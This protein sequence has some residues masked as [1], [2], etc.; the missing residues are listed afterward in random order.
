MSRLVIAGLALVIA[1]TAC[2]PPRKAAVF[3]RATLSQAQESEKLGGRHIRIVQP[4]DTLFG[5]AFAN[6]L[7]AVKLAAWNGVSSSAKLQI[8]QRLRLTQP[9]G[10][11]SE[12][13][14]QSEAVRLDRSAR[15]KT[16]KPSRTEPI[17]SG[18][19]TVNTNETNWR[20]PVGGA[21]LSRFNL[22]RGQQGV[23][24]GAPLGEPV[25]AAKSGEVVYVG[26]GLKGYGNL[27]IVKHHADFI[28]AYAHNLETFVREGQSVV[29]GQRLATVGQYK[30]RSALHFQIRQFGEPIDPLIHLP[31]IN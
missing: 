20:W 10:F 18:N 4:G 23:D 5:I 9:L 13:Q 2:S 6:G 12:S 22:A 26:N 1:L 29:T 17:T 14:S 27:V 11:I 24:I 15:L 30:G 31:K 25:V 19:A 21:L 7:D 3:E 16:N 8:G 28:S